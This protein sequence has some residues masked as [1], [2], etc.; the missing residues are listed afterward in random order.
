M[1]FSKSKGKYFRENQWGAMKLQLDVKVMMIDLHAKNQLNIYKRLGKNCRKLFDCWNLLSQRSVISPK[2]MER[3][4]TQ[5][6][7]VSHG[8]WLTCPKSGQYLQGF[9]KKSP[10]NCL[11]AEIY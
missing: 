7:S 5:T 6:L 2:S 1:E 4:E 8:D 10:E 9:R 11:I 3:K